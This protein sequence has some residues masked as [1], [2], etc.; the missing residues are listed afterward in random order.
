M[1]GKTSRKVSNDWKNLLKKF[2]SLEKSSKKVPM[3]G[4]IAK[5]SS[6]DWKNLA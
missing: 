5:K 2:Q 6:N 1:I 3:I 4:K